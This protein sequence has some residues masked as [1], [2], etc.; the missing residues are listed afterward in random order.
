MSFCGTTANGRSVVT[1]HRIA[2]TQKGDLNRGQCLL[3]AMSPEGSEP[4]AVTVNKCE[5]PAGTITTDGQRD[6]PLSCGPKGSFEIGTHHR[7]VA[8]DASACV[9]RHEKLVWGDRDDKSRQTLTL[10][11]VDR[12]EQRFALNLRGHQQERSNAA[13]RSGIPLV[14]GST[15]DLYCILRS[16]GDR[17][18]FSFGR[19][20]CLRRIAPHGPQL[21][22]TTGF[23]LPSAP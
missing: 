22:T 5:A 14:R 19:S 12:L 20:Y 8:I 13:V 4:G 7:T 6:H 9:A 1:A 3:R 17:G 18:P 16:L 21:P 10:A 23:S 11:F 2:M 15:A